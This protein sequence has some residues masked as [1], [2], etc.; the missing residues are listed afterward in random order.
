M[1][2]S[3]PRPHPASAGDAPKPRAPLSP[4]SPT[5]ARS[6]GRPERASLP[7]SLVVRALVD[8]G[9]GERARRRRTRG[10][11]QREAEFLAEAR[12]YADELR[13]RP[14]PPTRAE[15]ERVVA[16]RGSWKSR[17]APPVASVALSTRLQR[18]CAA[19][20][21]LKA[22]PAA[23]AAAPKSPAP[24][25]VPSAPASSAATGGKREQS[26]RRFRDAARAVIVRGRAQARLVMLREFLSGLGFDPVRLEEAVQS[27]AA[28]AGGGNMAGGGGAA[29]R[30][31]AVTVGAA[32]LAVSATTEQICE[33]GHL[34]VEFM[35]RHRM[36]DESSQMR[37]VPV[38]SSALHNLLARFDI[39]RP[40]AYLATMES[41]TWDSMMEAEEM[42][43]GAECLATSYAPL[44]VDVPLKPIPPDEPSAAPAQPPDKR[45]PKQPAAPT[46][47]AGGLL[48]PG[49]ALV[50]GNSGHLRDKTGPPGT[51]AP[52]QPPKPPQPPQTTQQQQQQQQQQ[53]PESAA[54]GPVAAG[55]D[56]DGKAAAG[57]AGG[58]QRARRTR[59]QQQQGASGGQPQ[60]GGGG[61]GAAAAAQGGAAAQALP[62]I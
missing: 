8:E 26:L 17:E 4:P 52:A 12:R 15:L 50:R 43:A 31:G 40:L 25:A 1:E 42:A 30:E 60:A 3:A 23:P 36:V 24:A 11:A 18:P 59:Q 10:R 22:P 34:H 21:L 41:R 27:A 56:K 45:G 54:A 35:P 57:G 48:A 5:A 46:T 53:P 62:P 32:P 39:F 29:S 9:P 37:P 51:A 49:P 55:A 47:G 44:L 33:A 61:G 16:E 2:R 38:D 19:V 7:H 14:N 6:P 13:L 58:A 28:A 20:S